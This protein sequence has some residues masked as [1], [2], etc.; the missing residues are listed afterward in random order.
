[1]RKLFHEQKLTFY[2]AYEYQLGYDF[3]CCSVIGTFCECWSM[4]GH[5][6]SAS[7]SD[8]PI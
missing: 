1:M 4:S 7:H 3:E 2:F 5:C 8:F 6:I